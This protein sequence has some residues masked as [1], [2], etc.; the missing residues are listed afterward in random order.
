MDKVTLDAFHSRIL[1]KRAMIPTSSAAKMAT[2]AKNFFGQGAK[3]TTGNIM[4][5][6]KSAKSQGF[7]GR[8]KEFGKDTAGIALMGGGV[9]A[10]KLTN[11]NKMLNG[12]RYT[13]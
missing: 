7:G 11:S 2:W 13:V 5:G 1:E 8:M 4:F 10:Y 6:M 9:G 3:K 12:G